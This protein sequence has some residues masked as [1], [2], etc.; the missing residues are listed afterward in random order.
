MKTLTQL[1]AGLCALAFL[2][3]CEPEV[4]S[5]DWCEMMKEKSPGDITAS[6]AA[7]MAKHCIL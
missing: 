7:D 5:E 2:T 1:A 4:G 6:E 3:A